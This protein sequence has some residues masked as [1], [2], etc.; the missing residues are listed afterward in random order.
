MTPLLEVRGLVKD[1]QSLRPLR[2]RELS[3]ADGEVLSVAGLDGPSAEMFVHL[4]TGA[5]LPDEGHVALFGRN[6]REVPDAEEWLQS[7]DGL[8][9]VSGRAVLLDVLSVL[10]NI[11]LPLTLDVDPMAPEVVDAVQSLA[12]EAG[13]DKAM[14]QKPLGE[15]DSETRLRVHV[16]R[17]V[18]A[19]PR[20]IV[21]EHPSADLPREA[22]ARVAHDLG[23]LARARRL[24]L[25]VLTA[26]PEF[27]R[28]LGGRTLGLTPATGELSETVGLATR[29]RRLFD[30]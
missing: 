30:R 13:I 3:V 7:L 2:V 20:L 11:A 25:L 28:G 8:G 18:A 9:L 16:A 10:Q 24:A 1:Y 14:W 22:V 23:G 12:G 29:L 5:A 19:Q 27:Q 17:A 15:V 21:A 6:T 4:L 26:D